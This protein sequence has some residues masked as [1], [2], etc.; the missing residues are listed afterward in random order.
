MG[1]IDDGGCAFPYVIH[2]VV[3][4]SVG[5]DHVRESEVEYGMSLRDYFAAKMLQVMFADWRDRGNESYYP[6]AA[7]IAYK[8]A[9]AMIEARK[10]KA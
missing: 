6:A 1:K 10:G 4:P 5:V 7:V 2:P 9:D 8:M 3:I